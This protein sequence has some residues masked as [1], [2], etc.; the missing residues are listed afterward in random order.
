[1]STRRIR[2]MKEAVAGMAGI[3]RIAATAAIAAIAAI[4]TIAFASLLLA[5]SA[6]AAVLGQPS[7]SVN[8]DIVDFP[9]HLLGE[10]YDEDAWWVAVENAPGG[11]SLHYL[12]ELT[13]DNASD[14]PMVCDAGGTACFEGWINPGFNVYVVVRFSPLFAG[15]RHARIKVTGSDTANPV[16]YVD[17]SG[18][19]TESLFGDG[20]EN[21]ETSSWSS[22]TGC[23]I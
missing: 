14:F 8:P 9:V 15:P 7:M 5:A 19:G 12:I 3:P 17:L 13:G 18:I 6:S 1:M 10:S 21:A 2:R 4:A 11:S 23:P 20:F 22:C 16:E